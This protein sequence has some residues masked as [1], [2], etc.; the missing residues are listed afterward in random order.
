ME[1]EGWIVEWEE[2]RFSIGIPGRKVVEYGALS[3][4]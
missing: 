3:V 4:L 1:G 2:V